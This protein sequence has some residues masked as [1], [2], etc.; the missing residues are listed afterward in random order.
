MATL[1]VT[2]I[3]SY[4]TSQ[5]LFGLLVSPIAHELG[6]SNAAIGAAYSGTVLVSGIAGLALG[7]A[8]DRFGARVLMSLGSLI[9]G[10]SLIAIASVHS[11]VAFDLLWTVGMG[12]G[13]ALTYYPVSFTVV[14]NWFD[15]QRA[16]ALAF[17]TFLGALA[18]PFFYPLAGLAIAAFGWRQAVIL[19]GALQLLVAF[20]LHALV[21]RRHPEDHGL[22]PDG[23][24]KRSDW[25]PE[26][27]L[28]F[29]GAMRSGAFWM[30]TSALSLAYFASTAILLQHVAYLIARGYAPALA[31]TLV[32]FFGIVYLPGRWLVAV[33]GKRISSTTLLAIAFL[34]EA[35]GIALLA[36]A[37]SIW[38]VG[39]Y[40][41][42]FGIAYGATAPLRG[43]IVAER[44]GRRAYGTIF[45]TQN[46]IVGVFAALGP[47]AAG[48][49]IDVSGY[50]PAFYVCIAACGA[51]AIVLAWTRT[52]NQPRSEAQIQTSR[53]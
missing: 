17:L 6:W 28:G 25:T 48:H 35:A 37:Q 2:T 11:L 12:V 33:A 31:A 19:M 29:A 34:M 5:Y 4:G 53:P 27:G 43:A 32:G 49:L 10:L 3:I 42:V 16:Q 36:F 51:A 40:V 15:R 24:A 8:L 30:L 26:S 7:R 14:A 21:V 39:A 47:I 46:A 20:P 38:W 52:S 41:L 45:A 22:H 9:G 1:G 50:L 23:A 18:S 44:F 13:T